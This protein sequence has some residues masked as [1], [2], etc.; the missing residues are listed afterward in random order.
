MNRKQIFIGSLPYGLAT[1]ELIAEL[2]ALFKFCGEINDQDIYLP[3]DSQTG[4]LRGYGFI[5]FTDEKSAQAAIKF[6]GKEF[7]ARQLQIS[8][9]RSRSHN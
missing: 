2:K 8:Y 6:N 4:R 3:T 9:A 1:I 5:T 7:H